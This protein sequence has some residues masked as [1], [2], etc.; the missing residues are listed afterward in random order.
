MCGLPR[1]LQDSLSPNNQ[2]AKTKE[3]EDNASGSLFS[4]ISLRPVKTPCLGNPQYQ[5]YA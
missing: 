2:T 4:Q 1:C 5:G 3:P